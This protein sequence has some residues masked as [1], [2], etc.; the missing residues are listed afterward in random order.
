MKILITGGNGYIATR[1]KKNLQEL[2]KITTV[3]RLDFDL[4]NREQTN[5][6]FEDRE[7]DIVIHTAA[8]GGNRLTTD[9]S[10]TLDQNLAMYYNI[11]ENKNNFKKFIHFGSGA[12]IYAKDSPY[13]ISKIAIA[14]SI[15]DKLNFYNIRIFAVFDENELDRRFIKSNILKYKKKESLTIHQDKKMDFFYMKDLVNLVRY[16]IEHDNLPKKI[17][18]TYE[19]TYTLSEIAALINN[20]DKHKCEIVVQN[21]NVAQQ[22]CGTFTPLIQYIGLEKGIEEVYKV[23]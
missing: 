19:K 22:Y 13:G 12:E 10:K 18:C 2:Y 16:Y 9:T 23:V 20:L 14:E 5:K 11:L 1:F 3:T 21:F 15:K 8:V 17:D 7:F 4:T 6:W